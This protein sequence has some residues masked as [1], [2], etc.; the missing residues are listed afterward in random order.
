MEHQTVGLVARV[1]E[2]L[3]IPTVCMTSARDITELVRPP[4]AV[5]VDFPLGHQTGKPFDRVL[6]KT[7]VRD[8]LHVLETA[9]E[10]GLIVDLPYQWGEDF[11]YVYPTVPGD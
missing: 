3:G 7:I 1:V 11:D 5:F 9:R 10:P 2:E 6:Q 4:R 8:A